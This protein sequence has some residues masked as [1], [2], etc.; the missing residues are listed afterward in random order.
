VDRKKKAVAPK[1]VPAFFYRTAAGGEP[2]RDWLRA[3]SDA[4]RKVIGADIMTVEFAWPIG[5]PASRPLGDG[6]HEV[7][8]QLPGKRIARIIFY[9]D[10]LQRMVLLH[11]FIKKT[12]KLDTGELAVAKRNKS[13]HERGLR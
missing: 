4:D 11:A 2:V 3:L 10:R 5:M 12:R 9:I 8:S 13:T 1:R 7:R 6:L